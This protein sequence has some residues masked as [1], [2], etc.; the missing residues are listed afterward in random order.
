MSTGSHK[1]DDAKKVLSTNKKKEK[2]KEVTI[3]KK[4]WN[5]QHRWRAALSGF[6]R[7]KKV[8]RPFLATSGRRSRFTCIIVGNVAVA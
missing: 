3:F 2:K 8:A 1:E 6:Q 4:A 5:A 7:P